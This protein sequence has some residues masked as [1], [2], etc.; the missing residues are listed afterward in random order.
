MP[1]SVTGED[2]HLQVREPPKKRGRIV[3][4]CPVAWRRCEHEQETVPVEI[5]G[6][7][8][9]VI[10]W[11]NGLAAIKSP[12]HCGQVSG[13]V[14]ALTGSWRA[15]HIIPRTATAD[16]YRHVYREFNKEADE[17]AN[18]AMDQRT[19]SEWWRRPMHLRPERLRGWFDGGRRNDDL[20]SCGWIVKASFDP[21]DSMVEPRWITM[22]W[23]SVLLPAG[24]TITE[25]EL[26]G[27]ELVSAALCRVAQD[28]FEEPIRPQL[29]KFR[30]LA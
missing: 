23:A 22:A 13:V 14:R 5:L 3:Q 17:L 25:A 12:T 1:A 21:F 19:S 26:T 18:K 27:A 11:L 16:W 20:V 2:K 24:T 15:G 6:D 10:S 29:S 4:E 7:S 9:L 28:I 8:E 30:R